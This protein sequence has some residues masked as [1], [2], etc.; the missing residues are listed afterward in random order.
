[1]EGTQWLIN[2]LKC[3]G[4]IVCHIR[5]TEAQKK[6]HGL[7]IENM[8]VAIHSIL[9]IDLKCQCHHNIKD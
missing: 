8:Y 3:K 5:T 1:M 7:I 2:M 6:K 4:I 9:R